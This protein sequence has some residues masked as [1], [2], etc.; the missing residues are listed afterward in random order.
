MV[1][2][3]CTV[4]CVFLL[5]LKLYFF[6]SMIEG[7]SWPRKHGDMQTTLQ[8]IVSTYL[9]HHGYSQVTII[10]ENS[11]LI[12]KDYRYLLRCMC[13]LLVTDQKLCFCQGCGSGSARIR[14]KLKGSIRNR[15]WVRI[16]VISWIRIRI[17]LW[18]QA[19]MYGIWACLALFK[20][21]E[22]LFG[23]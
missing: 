18:S 22:P 23:S 9:V 8:R 2:Y 21:F 13:C 11:W 6:R 1:L 10:I 5:Q 3:S 7:L 16:K 17:D 4:L 19:K 20:S 15:I 14:I 12:L